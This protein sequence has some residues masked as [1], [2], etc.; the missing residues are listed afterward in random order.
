HESLIL[1]ARHGHAAVT[2][3]KV[4]VVVV[5]GG[6]GMVVIAL[7]VR[8]LA[9]ATPRM[10]RILAPLLVGAL[11]VA[12]RAVLE[13][14]FTLVQR[15]SVV[16]FDY[17]FWWQIA[18]FIALPLALLAGLLRARLARATVGDLVLELQH[19]PPHGLRGALARALDDPTL[20]VALWL[21]DRH[22]YVNAAGRPVDLP[23]GEAGRAITYLDHEGEP[24]AALVHDPSLLDEPKLVQAAGAAARMALE[25]ARLQADMRAQLAKV[26][27]SRVRI[28]AAADDERR[29][30][31][32]DLHDGAQQRLVAIA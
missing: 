22:V 24:L 4:F 15:P 28:V 5:W 26:Q 14:V 10:R 11:A 13:G 3:Q 19:A 12:L 32:R 17:L 1:V 31:E 9:R 29:R 20:D 8:K 21:P 7:I 18:S 23:V 2:I 27:E 6:L 30:I 25:N 16:L